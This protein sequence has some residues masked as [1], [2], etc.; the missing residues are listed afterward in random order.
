[1]SKR[2]VKCQLPRGSETWRPEPFPGGDAA[3]D[4]GCTCPAVQ[5][6]PGAFVFASDCPVH[7]IERGLQS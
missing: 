3:R 5:P 7:E 1:M 6:W 2:Y 4:A